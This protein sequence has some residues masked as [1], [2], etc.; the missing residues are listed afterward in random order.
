MTFY[1]LLFCSLKKICINVFKI[2]HKSYFMPII[3]YKNHYLP[4]KPIKGKGRNK[5]YHKDDKYNMY[6]LIDTGKKVYQHYKNDKYDMYS[7]ITNTGKKVYKVNGKPV[8]SNEFKEILSREFPGV[9]NNECLT[10]DFFLKDFKDDV[11]GNFFKCYSDSQRAAKQQHVNLSQ[12]KNDFLKEL[13]LKLNDFIKKGTGISNKDVIKI[14]N[15]LNSILN[16][17]NISDC[18]NT[19]NEVLNSSNKILEDE[20]NSTNKSFLRDI[21]NNNKET[22]IIANIDDF[23]KPMI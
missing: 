8:D 20:C 12:Q 5:K 4:F 2:Y 1:C 10:P 6:S 3:S 14:N 18:K 7:L 13:Q 17:K 22:Q 23:P 11:F 19:I 9:V 15:I 16:D 21:N